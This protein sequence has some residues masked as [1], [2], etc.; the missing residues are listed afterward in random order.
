MTAVGRRA[1]SGRGGVLG[2]WAQTVLHSLRQGCLGLFS[3][4]GKCN[5]IGRYVHSNQY[6][7][8]VCLKLFWTRER[9]LN[10]VRYKSKVCQ[11]NLLLRGPICSEE[12]SLAADIECAEANTKLHSQ[13]RRRHFAEEPVLQ[14]SGP[15][16]YEVLV[17]GT[18]SGHHR[19]GQGHNHY[20]STGGG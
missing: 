16:Q 9:L 17:T 5:M 11:Q 6:H 7:C 15:L 12:E 1:G 20:G 18:D 19:L 4:H 14:L 10:H 13:S 8:S 3:K 2:P